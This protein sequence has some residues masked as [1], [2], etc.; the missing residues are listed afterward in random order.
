MN[1]PHRAATSFIKGHTANVIV[2][3][4]PIKS[5]YSSY[6]GSENYLVL[7]LAIS[8]KTFFGSKS[9]GYGSSSKKKNSQLR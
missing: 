4:D 7:N 9:V 3:N 2:G 1:D 8:N 5:P 6:H